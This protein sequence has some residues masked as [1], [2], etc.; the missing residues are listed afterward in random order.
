MGFVDKLKGIL[1]WESMVTL[2]VFFL[3]LTA[4]GIIGMVFQ[5][6]AVY[7]GVL[8]AFGIPTS[9]FGNLATSASKVSAAANNPSNGNSKELDDLRICL[10]DT[11]NELLLLKSKIGNG[12]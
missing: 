11:R 6:E 1:T 7:I 10:A 12:E 5:I 8:V 9:I 4:F 2:T 3:C